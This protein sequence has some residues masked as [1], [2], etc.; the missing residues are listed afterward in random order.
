VT[1]LGEPGIGKS[2]LVQ[3]LQPL[4]GSNATFL[5][6]RCPAYGEGITYWPVRE[7][8]LQAAGPSPI[9]ELVRSLEDGPA[10]ARGVATALGLEEGVAGEEVLWAFRRFF[11]EI[12]RT[13][14]LVLVFEDVHYGQ[15]ALVDV[16]D[17]LASWIRD[18]PVLLLCLARPELLD[19]HRQWAGGQR[20]AAS[21]TLGPL[22]ADES[23]ELLVA[24]AGKTLEEVGLARIAAT[25]GG[26]PFF[27][28]QLLAHVG[29][30]GTNAADLGLPPVLQ[31][32]LAARLDLLSPPERAVLEHG[33]V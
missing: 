7:M 1:V 24:L 3:E 31:A 27:L 22:S 15:A 9:D 19:T 33:A 17:H 25:A 13:Q 14:P 28:E 2:R 11:A 16:V 18:V 26:N 20:N 30:R 32:L 23:R 12:A 8:V 21:L 5:M 10:V 4:L 6:G 29:E